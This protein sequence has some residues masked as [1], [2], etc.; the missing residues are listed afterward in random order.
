MCGSAKVEGS[1][2]MRQAN[3]GRRPSACLREGDDVYLA[4]RRKSAVISAKGEIDRQTR[5]RLFRRLLSCEKKIR[6]TCRFSR[7]IGTLFKD[8]RCYIFPS[9]LSIRLNI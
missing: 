8:Y 9:D 2:G 4:F 5:D 7:E 3:T 6:T 1:S